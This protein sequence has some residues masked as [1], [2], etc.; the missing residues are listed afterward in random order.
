MD[1]SL[2]AFG[3]RLAL[4]CACCWMPAS[5]GPASADVIVEYRQDTGHAWQDYTHNSGVTVDGANVSVTNPSGMWRIRMSDPVTQDL[6]S[7]FFN[8]TSGTA[9][10][11][12]GGPSP[13]TSARLA[14]C[15]T[16]PA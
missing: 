15:L 8:G 13:P 6:G 4:A 9:T 1:N 14:R 12:I 5:V 2:F 11:L 16:L 10:V 7:V 3:R